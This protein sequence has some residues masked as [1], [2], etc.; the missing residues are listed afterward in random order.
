MMNQANTEKRTPEPDLFTLNEKLEDEKTAF[1]NR[2]NKKKLMEKYRI[3]CITG[4]FIQIL[5]SLVKKSIIKFNHIL[6]T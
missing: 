5:P 6:I 2:K 1:S 3:I 4:I